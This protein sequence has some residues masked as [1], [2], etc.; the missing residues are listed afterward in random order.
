[1]KNN[2]QEYL[3]NNKVL[4]YL[5][6]QYLNTD[7]LLSFLLFHLKIDNFQL[8][9]VINAAETIQNVVGQ[10]DETGEFTTIYLSPKDYH[11]IHMP[12]AGRLREMVYVPGKLFS[13][14]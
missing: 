13:V 8:N 5:N 6:L 11:R 7:K 4:T 14:N 3:G 12:M 1:M 10:Y 2:H 9:R